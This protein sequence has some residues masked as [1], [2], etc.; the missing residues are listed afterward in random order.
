MEKVSNLVGVYRDD[1]KSRRGE[2]NSEEFSN[3]VLNVEI[4][5]AP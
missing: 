1:M 3:K 5:E 4:D 2:R